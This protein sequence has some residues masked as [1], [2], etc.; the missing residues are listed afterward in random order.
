M[1]FLQKQALLPL[2]MDVLAR[3]NAHDADSD[4]TT[5]A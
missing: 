5:L 4:L 3:H 1:P 2:I